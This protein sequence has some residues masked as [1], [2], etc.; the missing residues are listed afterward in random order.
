MIMKYIQRTNNEN[1]YH[2]DEAFCSMTSSTPGLPWLVPAAAIPCAHCRDKH[3]L[4]DSPC[5]ISSRE[6]SAKYL[7]E[8]KGWVN[9]HTLA[10]GAARIAAD[11]SLAKVPKTN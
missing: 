10:E 2:I 7:L 5:H 11:R 3:T 6:I 9:E 1:T 8:H 4:L